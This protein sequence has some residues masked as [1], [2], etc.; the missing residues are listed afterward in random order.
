[1]SP[2]F[3]TTSGKIV[4]CGIKLKELRKRYGLSQELFA[5]KCAEQG[6]S[7]SSASIKRAEVGKHILYRTARDIARFFNVDIEKLLLEENTVLSSSCIHPHK[8]THQDLFL[9][10]DRKVTIM[11]CRLRNYKNKDITPDI[12]AQEHLFN[13]FF[14]IVSTTIQHQG[15]IIYQN[16]GD[17]IIAV[18]GIPKAY[19]LY[20]ER[21]LYAAFKIQQNFSE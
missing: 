21:C 12:K 4:L 9:D 16:C 2:Q 8:S 17:I 18:F 15:G 13:N 6:L 1:M 11:V 20:T 5:I 14:D 7:V 19:Y 10:Q 3:Q